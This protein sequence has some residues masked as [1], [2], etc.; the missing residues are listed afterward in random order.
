LI[1][2]A[3][4][5]KTRGKSKYPLFRAEATEPARKSNA[6][7]YN[8]WFAIKFAKMERPKDEAKVP[9]LAGSILFKVERPR[10]E[11]RFPRLLPRKELP[12][13]KIAGDGKFMAPESET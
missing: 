10:G 7:K 12:A 8:P 13:E 5:G 11:E 6:I 4:V 3:E 2:P 1:S 9:R